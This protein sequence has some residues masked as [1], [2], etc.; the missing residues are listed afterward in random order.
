MMKNAFKRTAIFL[1]LLSTLFACKKKIDDP[2]DFTIDDQNLTD[3]PQGTSCNFQ[4]ANYASM[5]GDQLTLTTGQHRIFWARKENN[6]GTSW[7][8]FQAPMFGDQF[9]LNDADVL[10]GRVKYLDACTTCFAAVPKPVGGT[11]KGIKIAKGGNEPEKWLLES[12]IVFG[13]ASD[14]LRIKQY[15]YPTVE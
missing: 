12:K 4:Y 5:D 8:Y 2:T 9:L 1:M 11:V 3:C 14:T 15:Y 10:A 6:H 13:G 7:L